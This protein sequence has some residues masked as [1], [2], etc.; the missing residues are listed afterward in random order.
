MRT[1]T[2]TDPVLTVREVAELLGVSYRT[3]LRRIED[4]SLR[5]VRRGGRF[6]VRQS[7]IDEFLTD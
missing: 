5:A 2:V 4:G 7:W 3:V 1:H 6:F